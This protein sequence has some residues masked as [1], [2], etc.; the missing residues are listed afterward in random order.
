MPIDQLRE[1]ARRNICGELLT[2]LGPI[3]NDIISGRF[4]NEALDKIK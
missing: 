2:P 3:E 1:I 4:I